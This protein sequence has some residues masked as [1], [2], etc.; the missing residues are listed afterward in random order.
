MVVYADIACPWATLAVHRLHAARS[1][2]GLEE[3]VQ[4]DLRAFPLELFNRRPTPKRTLD[5]EWA[6]I[7]DHAADFGW[8]GWRRPDWEYPGTTLLALEAVQAAKEQGLAASARLDLG[9]RRGMF[10]DS[11]C[12]SLRHVV[13][14]IANECRLDA[15]WLAEALDDGRAR[16]AVIEQW[17]CAET[18]EVQG[19]PHFFLPDGSDSHNP[20]IDMHW[21][22][23]GGRGFPVIER[24]DPSVYDDLLARAAG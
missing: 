23:E 11:R 9:L 8:S 5:V 20:G 13:L 19:S 21:H 3:Q 2:L 10:V 18:D 7:A 24:D 14:D 4:V 22:G 15:T 16:R 17:H 1:R 6:V 12:I